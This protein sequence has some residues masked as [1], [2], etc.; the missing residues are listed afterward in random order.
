MP[1]GARGGGVEG[2]GTGGGGVGGDGVERTRTI[3][4][5]SCVPGIEILHRKAK[6]VKLDSHIIISNKF[7]HRD[8]VL[9]NF[10]CVENII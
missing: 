7:A 3:A 8:K 4:P 5:Q 2:C 1:N 9:D 10:G 6:G